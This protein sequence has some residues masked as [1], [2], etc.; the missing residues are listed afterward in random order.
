[1][2]NTQFLVKIFI[3]KIGEAEKSAD[4]PAAAAK[5]SIRDMIA[6]KRAAMKKP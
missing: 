1:M 6:A 2:I 3:N 5:S 4:K